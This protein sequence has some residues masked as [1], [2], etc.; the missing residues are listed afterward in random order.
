[1]AETRVTPSNGVHGLG[2]SHDTDVNVPQGKTDWTVYIDDDKLAKAKA[3]AASAKIDNINWFAW[4]TVK[5]KNGQHVK[6]TYTVTFDAPTD[7]GKHTFY[8]Y[9]G[10]TVKEI[11]TTGAGRKG[12][13][14]RMQV[15]FSVGDPGIGMT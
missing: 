15:T 6:E 14:A 10:S 11:G 13:K 5:D 12:N 7:G 1:M 4:F 2:G 8:A 9:D 3:A